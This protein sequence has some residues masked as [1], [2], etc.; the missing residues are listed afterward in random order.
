MTLTIVNDT[1]TGESQAG[2]QRS[3]LR[4]RSSSSSFDT[5]KIHKMDPSCSKSCITDFKILQGTVLDQLSKSETKSEALVKLKEHFR[6]IIGS[7]RDFGRI[8]DFEGLFKIL[9]KRDELSC[10]KLEPFK[11]ASDVIGDRNLKEKISKFEEK[12]QGNEFRDLYENGKF[13]SLK[14]NR[15]EGTFFEE[16]NSENDRLT[17]EDKENNLKDEVEEKNSLLNESE[18]KKL[19]EDPTEFRVFEGEKIVRGLR[20]KKTNLKSLKIII[21]TFILAF[22]I[23]SGIAF[24]A[25]IFLR[26]TATTFDYENNSQSQ[27]AHSSRVTS[28][29]NIRGFQPY[30]SAKETEIEKRGI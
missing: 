9:K 26:F 7:N 21:C 6:D 14:E 10:S 15:L 16:E 5:V 3:E 25:S 8:R 23:F 11:F 27:E 29:P 1:L 2:I 4:F 30:N 24:Y 13:P 17:S 19:S 18:L 12:Y 20:R 22:L 28:H